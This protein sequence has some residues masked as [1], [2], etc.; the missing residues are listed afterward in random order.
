MPIERIP[1]ESEQAWHVQRALF[2]N[3][4]EMGIVCGEGNYGSLAELFAEKKGLRPPRIAT[5]VMKRGKIGEASAFEALAFEQPEW[6]VKRARV[7]VRD[8]ERRIACT[9]DGFATAPGRDGIGVVQAKVIGRSVFRHRWLN[10][11]ADSI[12]FGEVTVPVEYRLQVLTEGMLNDTN[13]G[14][15]AVLI[16]GEYQWDFRLFDIERDPVLED[17]I[18]FNVERFVREYLDANIMPPYNP[19]RDEELIRAL[20]P[21]DD[22]TEIDLSTDNRVAVLVEELTEK[23]AAC[24]R[25]DKE[26]KGIKTELTAKLGEHTYGRLA[27]GRRLSWKHQHRKAHTVP[28]SDFRVLRIVNE[29]TAT[30]D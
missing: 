11:P 4:S 30:D 22:G 26:V 18:V 1:I 13:W 23:Q 7:H 2:V 9:P 20:Y 8:T 5:S 25:L 21:K 6:D 17:R 15:L 28:A 3:A 19:L 27:D 29:R 24:K 12:E 16:T 14:V 10:D